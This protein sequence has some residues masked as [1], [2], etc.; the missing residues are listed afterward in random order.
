VR[1]AAARPAGRTISF[2]FPVQAAAFIIVSA[3]VFGLLLS[4]W[5]LRQAAREDPLEREA[6]ET[7]TRA[8]GWRLSK[9]H[10]QGKD[11]HA[12]L[13]LADER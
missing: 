7:E 9:R 11:D 1:R 10:P 8:L 12:R 4:T 5:L 2:H 3:A 6:Y 13:N